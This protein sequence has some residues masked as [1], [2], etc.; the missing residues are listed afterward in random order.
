MNLKKTLAR[1]AATASMVVVITAVVGSAIP[2]DANASGGLPPGRYSMN[3]NAYCQ[4]R[5]GPMVHAI[6]QDQHNAY[7]WDCESYPIP[8]GV[9]MVGEYAVYKWESEK[10]QINMQDVCDCMIG[11][12]SRASVLD[13]HAPGTWGCDDF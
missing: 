6:A 5:Y 10:Y 1:L 4:V 8:S 12:G 3:L 9:D 13:S 7:S 11:D 2:G